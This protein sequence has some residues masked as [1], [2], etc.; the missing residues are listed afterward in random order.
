MPLT[1][2]IYIYV[3]TVITL[4]FDR[5][6]KS[7]SYWKEFVSLD[8]ITA[9]PHSLKVFHFALAVTHQDQLHVLRHERHRLALII[10]V[11]G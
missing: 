11:L 10:R 6:L 8:P 3:K 1:V 9:A 5:P 4:Y 7:D 2:A